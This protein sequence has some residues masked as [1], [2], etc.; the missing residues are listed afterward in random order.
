MKLS[1]VMLVIF[2]LVL[3]LLCKSV[4]QISSHSKQSLLRERTI[5]NSLTD[6]PKIRDDLIYRDFILIVE[7]REL[8]NLESGARRQEFLVN[9]TSPGP[10]LFA[11][12]GETLRI[13]V[14]NRIKP[15]VNSS[16]TSSG[17]GI[18]WH[19]I[20]QLGSVTSDGVVGLTQC[21]IPSAVT[22]ALS[23]SANNYDDSECNTMIYTFT[24]QRVGTFWYHGHHDDQYPNGMY[25]FTFLNILFFSFYLQRIF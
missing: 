10:A 16:H 19:G 7:S 9:G 8:V 1:R 22:C 24:P 14:V 21:A 20:S 4:E 2:C 13:V 18:H 3:T 5:G 23:S 6:I 25:T 12:L 17:T 15:F 11:E